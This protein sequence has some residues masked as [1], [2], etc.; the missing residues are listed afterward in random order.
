M[1]VT[2]GIPIVKANA[3]HIPK[4]P[5]AAIVRIVVPSIPCVIALEP[6]AHKNPP[7][8]SH[9]QSCIILNPVS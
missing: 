2:S 6:A 5:P 8:V 4:G 7:A 1:V 3:P 9:P